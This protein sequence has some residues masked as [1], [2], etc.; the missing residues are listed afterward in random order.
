MIWSKRCAPCL[1]SFLSFHS[2]FLRHVFDLE[3]NT[4][5]SKNVIN[6]RKYLFLN[7]WM[8][9][10]FKE[11]AVLVFFLLSRCSIHLGKGGGF[12]LKSLEDGKPLS[13]IPLLLFDGVGVLGQC[14]EAILLLG[15][16]FVT[17][18]DNPLHCLHEQLSGSTRK[19]KNESW[20]EWLEIKTHCLK[21]SI[22]VTRACAFSKSPFLSSLLVNWAARSCNWRNYKIKLKITCVHSWRQALTSGASLLFMKSKASW[23]SAASV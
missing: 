9:H 13:Q 7:E 3:E 2:F 10:I 18:F 6:K 4:N 15:Y 1:P 14:L 20:E 5:R 16:E 22:L 21:V 17:L 12:M 23:A 8:L 11:H 19:R